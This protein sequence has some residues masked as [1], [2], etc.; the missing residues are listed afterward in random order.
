M[1]AMNRIRK[2]L[3][4]AGLLL[5]LAATGVSAAEQAAH[6]HEHGGAPAGLS[7]DEG[8]KWATDGPLRKA[9]AN[10]RNAMDASAHD[11]H[12]GKLSAARYGELARKVNGEVAYMVSNC[13]LEPRADAQL[14]LIIADM[15]E[16]AEA[17]EGKAKQVKRRDGAVKVM[18]AL[19][20]YGAY[21]ADPGWKPA[22]H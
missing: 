11:I 4:A 9:M 10:I 8:R 3:A 22:G 6:Q 7:L 21:F 16:G 13:K 12:E 20:N 2:F 18:G 14:H 1:S 15:L 17:M 19:E 5:G